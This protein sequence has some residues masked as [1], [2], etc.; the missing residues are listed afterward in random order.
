MQKIIEETIKRVVEANQKSQKTAYREPLFGYGAADDPL[1]LKLKTAAVGSGHLLP[2]ELLPEAKTVVAFFLPF[3]KEL[4]EHNRKHGYIAKS[5]AEAYIETNALISRCCE[6]LSATLA[7]RGVKAAWQEPTHNFDPVELCAK[8]SHKHVAYICGLGTFGLHQMLITPAGC[9]G[10]FGSLVIDQ[11][12]SPTPLALEDACLF[13]QNGS[14][15]ACV[16]KCPSGAL[17]QEGLDKQKCYCYLL[18]VDSFY[19]GI[20]LSDVCGKCAVW[21][22]CAIIEDEQ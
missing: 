14:C 19:S 3:T 7:R 13:L 21:G 2:S 4:V 15:Q 17:T 1:F 18:E 12:L 22:P 9:A 6:E 10:R 16:K 5:W 8:W 20:G 11:T